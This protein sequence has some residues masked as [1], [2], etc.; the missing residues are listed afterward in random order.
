V[1]VMN[2]WHMCERFEAFPVESFY[3]C[4]I[5]LMA[6]RRCCVERFYV[7]CVVQHVYRL[8]GAQVWTLEVMVDGKVKVK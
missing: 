8:C 2:D 7:E 3:M 6:S 1:C 5:R 4:L